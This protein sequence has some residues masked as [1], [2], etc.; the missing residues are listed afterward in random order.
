M[1]VLRQGPQHFP[2]H[3]ELRFG[4]GKSLWAVSCVGPSDGRAQSVVC[5]PQPWAL[6]TD[7]GD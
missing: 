3:L 5:V 2:A 6:L 7:L 1:E 4:L